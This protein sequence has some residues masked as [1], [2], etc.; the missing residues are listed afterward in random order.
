MKRIAF[1][2]SIFLL[3]TT[4]FYLPASYATSQ[5][6][7][8]GIELSQLEERIDS[9]VEQFIGITTPGAAI[10]VVNE[11]EVIFSKGYGYSD[12]ENK[13]PV[14]PEE[15]IFE[16]G[17]IS[18]LFVWTAA[19]QLVEQGKL[20]LNTDIRTYLP[21]EINEK[22]L[23]K[24]SITMNNLMSHTAGFEDYYFDLLMPTPNQIGTLEDAVVR[25][26]PHQVYEPGTI[27]AYSNYSTALAAYIIEQITGQPFSNYEMEHIF[28]PL[29]MSQTSGHPTLADY[30][31]L[32]K[33]K[34]KGYF[35]NQEGDFKE[36]PWS[37]IPLYPAGSVNGTA[38]DLAKYA[39]ALMPIGSQSLIFKDRNT[40]D[41]MLTQSYSP[42]EYMLSNAHGFWE[43]AGSV[44]GLG[45]GG[46][47]ATMSAN[48]IIVP[49]ERFG[50]IVLTNASGEMAITYGLM[51]LLLGTSETQ[52]EVSKADLPSSREIEGMYISARQSITTYTE[53]LG[54]TMP[55]NVTA[56]GENEILINV[57]GLEGRYTQIQPYLYQLSSNG[58]PI[59]Y[60][61]FNKIY[62]EMDE[63]G[64]RRVTTGKI[65][66]YLPLDGDRQLP[67]LISSLVIAGVSIVFF[68]IAPIVLFL[69]RII[70]RNKSK[71]ESTEEKLEKRL[72]RGSIF[73]GSIILFN[74]ILLI[75]RSMMSQ[76]MLSYDGLK[77]H[78]IINWILLVGVM[79]IIVINLYNWKYV[80][81]KKLKKIIRIATYALIILFIAVLYNWNYFNFY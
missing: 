60:S 21:D 36:G 45:H 61:E 35:P 12:I 33:K 62:F 55:I 67:W 24:N 29:S 18:K 17:S 7:P 9:F 19:M 68:A 64:V 11:G 50:V 39:I 1:V 16:Y 46:N 31:S 80:K 23:F 74:N 28:S 58:N 15:T 4:I 44:R 70:K 38:K 10:T 66:D 8:S 76:S 22:L 25:Y 30:P 75:I 43:Y 81:L 48:L 77:I 5:K 40:L 72:Y 26:Q 2:L 63:T 14:D 13:I 6:T 69:K 42:N 54:Y 78:L 27:I 57:Y 3:G 79:V 41:D 56:I 59:L 53:L 34:A 71:S 32:I 20:D 73:L 37:Y 49:E 65:A 47:T 52:N 51:K